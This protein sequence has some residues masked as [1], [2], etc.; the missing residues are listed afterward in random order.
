MK[1]LVISD[2]HYEKKVYKGVDES[3]AWVWLLS[4]V[5]FHKPEYLLSCGDWG[6]AVSLSEFGELTDRTVVLTIYGNHENMPV[7]EAV[8]NV[9]WG[10]PFPVLVR[11][12][13]VYDVGGLK[14]AGLNGIISETGMPKKGV[15][16]RRPEEFLSAARMLMHVKVDVLLM[17]ETPYLPNVFGMAETVG[18]TTALRVVKAVKPE[19]VVNGH[20]HRGGY[21]T[22][23]FPFGTRYIYIDS[24][25]KE[26]HY[27][28]L[29]DDVI[30]IWR[31]LTFIDEI[32][33][34]D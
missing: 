8:Y 28:L 16:R 6:S 18:S 22:F 20:M 10:E 32:T 2:L 3:L 29:E 11:E 15:P 27:L 30:S 14:V 17:H 31:D 33:L 5:D 21:R 24:S 1:V 12:G 7:L 19:I 25:Q 26:K 13:V 9:R 34:D 23:T 4:V